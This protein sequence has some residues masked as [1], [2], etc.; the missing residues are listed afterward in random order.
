MVV[1]QIHQVE[2]DLEEGAAE[3]VA[4]QEQVVTE[5]KINLE[6][7]VVLVKQQIF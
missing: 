4:P 2:A 1:A 5:T 3:V 7:Q 6:V